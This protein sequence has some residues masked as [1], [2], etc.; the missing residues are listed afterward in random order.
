MA[1][2]LP[3][4]A[5]NCAPWAADSFDHIQGDT[6]E[7]VKFLR[8]WDHAGTP[9]AVAVDI[10]VWDVQVDLDAHRNPYGTMSC[11]ARWADV[12]PSQLV[13]EVD[14]TRFYLY[15][16][17]ISGD[18]GIDVTRPGQCAVELFAGYMR[19]G[20]PDVHTLFFGFVTTIR[21]T[22]DGTQHV[23]ELQAETAEIFYDHPRHSNVSG[24]GDYNVPDTHTNIAQVTAQLND[25]GR[26]P[27]FYRPPIYLYVPFTMATPNATQLAAFRGLVLVAGE[28]S[29]DGFLRSCAESLDQWLRGDVRNL[30]G[31]NGTQPHPGAYVITD[32][33]GAVMNGVTDGWNAGALPIDQIARS[34]SRVDSILDGWASGTKLTMKFRSVSGDETSRSRLF[35]NNVSGDYA[36]VVNQPGGVFPVIREQTIWRR[37][38]GGV[39]SAGDQVGARYAFANSAKSSQT[40]I[41]C[42]AA[43]WLEPKQ[44]I[45]LPLAQ[46][47]Q[48]SDGTEYLRP[49]RD[50]MGYGDSYQLEPAMSRH[51]MQV[52]SVRFNV[53][54]GEMTVRADVHNLYWI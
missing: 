48:T 5:T 14:P 34:V 26:A 29:I 15:E 40:I 3:P 7:P 12:R 11:K 45:S 36:L 25:A 21:V 4:A 54:A 47:R 44:L 23:A 31:Y 52:A 10:D 42:R 51:T 13:E 37:P 1:T 8:R 22:W 39:L 32:N 46:V 17:G 9:G 38:P 27:T 18:L 28:D 41:E 50:S 33:Y 49:N 20:V 16:G 19:G 53:D 6:V 35:T 24:D 43:F 30:F 2:V